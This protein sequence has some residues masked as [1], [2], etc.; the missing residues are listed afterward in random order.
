[1]NIVFTGK[2][3]E[4]RK[5]LEEIVTSANCHIQKAVTRDTDILFVGVRGKQFVNQGYGEKSTK[6]R[7]A[8]RLGIK[9][10]YINS[11]EEVPQYLI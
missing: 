1:M 3:A 8:E 2:L 4:N 7:T 9:I 11:I 5:E 6:E 10:K